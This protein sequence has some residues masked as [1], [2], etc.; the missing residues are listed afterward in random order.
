MNYYAV[1]GVPED[2]GSDAIHNAYRSLARQYHP[3]AGE[4]S[5]AANFRDVVEAY[6]T[7]SD[8]GRRKDYDA[9]LARQRRPAPPPHYTPPQVV[10]EPLAQPWFASRVQP[11][12]ARPHFSPVVITDNWFDQLFQSFEE[13]FSD[14]WFYRR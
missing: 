5:S 11:S 12:Y 13:F 14:A 6:N 7:L 4:G 3:D 10:V 2:A 1:L 8:P 9:A